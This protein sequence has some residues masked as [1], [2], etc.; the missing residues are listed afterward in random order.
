[1][2]LA[3]IDCG[4][5]SIRLL[6]GQVSDQGS[7]FDEYK[8]LMRIVR[9]GQDV[10]KTGAFAP[11]ALER[12]M[13]AV[14]EYAQLIN[15]YGATKIRFIATSAS[16]DVSNRDAFVD[17]VK[18]RLG[19]EPEVISGKEEASLSFRGATADL[20]Q[21]VERPVMVVDIGGGST[22]MVIGSD[23]IDQSVSMNIGS[24]RIFERFFKDLDFSTGDGSM[25]PQVSGKEW[26]RAFVKASRYID[27]QI[28][29][30]AKEIDIFTAHSLVG[31][32]GTV[33]TIAAQALRLN[34]Y[35]PDKIHNARISPA[36]MMRAI[37]DIQ[38][39]T[40]TQRA[41]LGFM[42]EG[43]A[44]VIGAGALVWMRIIDQFQRESI[45]AG[46]EDFG[47]IIVSEHDILD[48][49]AMSLMD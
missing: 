25:D 13:A 5:N 32:A 29:Q 7:T 36:D 34:A 44:D 9:L 14:D 12:T 28:L 43:R 8:R 46:R 19:V 26:G 40:V 21:D 16:R 11:E 41:K 6:L 47:N 38:N 42:P 33:T 23:D 3:A 10:D 31:V 48:G 35:E 37:F 22:E 15:D 1:M 30:A 18:K 17:G 20:S 2:K 27:D 39:M 45:S 24:V 4:T 49:I